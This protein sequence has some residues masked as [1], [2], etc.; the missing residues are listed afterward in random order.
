[1]RSVPT[2]TEN[3]PL[4]IVP[5]GPFDQ[6]LKA[7]IQARGLSLE[8]LSRRLRALGSPVSVACLSHWQRGRNRPERA[9]SL[10][11]VRGLEEI[12]GLP[13]HSLLTLLKSKTRYQ[14]PRLPLDELCEQPRVKGLVDAIG[15]RTNGQM[16]GLSLHSQYLLGRNGQ[17]L[18]TRTRMVFQARQ[19]GVDRW[20]AVYSHQHG[21]LPSA[22]IAEGCRFGR[23]RT[24]DV[25]AIATELLFDHPLAKGETYLLEYTFTFDE[26]GPPMTGDGRAFRIPMHQFMLDVRF[27]PEAVPTRCFRVW[28]PDGRTPLQDRTQLRLSL[29]NS[30]HFLDFG[31]DGGYHG[32]RWEWD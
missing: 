26:S 31:L 30:V 6:A 23:T 3:D 25:G 15:T 9:D 29:Y 4:Q 5:T 18:Q 22:R 12:L 32:M 16:V 11:A 14:A 17:L 27:H 24:D 8:A 28:R 10:K 21:L 1:M 13:R 2:L 7:A 19:R 20:I